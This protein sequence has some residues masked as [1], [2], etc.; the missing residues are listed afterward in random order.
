M[1]RIKIPFGGLSAEQ[2]D[3]L[4]ELRRGVLGRHPARHHAP[5][6]P[7]AL[8]PHRGHAR[9][10]APA[11]RGR[12]HDARGVRQLGPQRHRLPVSPASATT[13]AFDVTPY[14]HARRPTSC[15]A[16]PTRRTS[17][18][19]SR[20]RSPAARSNACG[21]TN[22]HDLGCIAVTRDGGRQAKRGFEFYVGGGLGAV[23]HAGQAASTSSCPRRSCCRS[24]RRSAACSRGSARRRTARA[25]ASSSWS[26]SSASRSS[27]AWCSRSAP[28]LRPD[29]RWTAFLADLARHRR[30]AAPRRPSRSATGR[31]PAGFDAWR[32]TNVQPQRQPGYAVATVTLPLGDLTADQA[33][34]L[35]DLSRTVHRRHDA[36]HRRAEPRRSA[37]CSEADLPALYAALARDRPRRR[38]APSTI[39]DITACPGTDTCKLGISSSRG[40]AGE[41]RKRLAARATSSD[42]GRRAARTSSAAAAST[43]AASTTSPTSASSASAATSTAAACRT[44][45]SW[46]AASG[47]NNAGA[48]GLAIGA[49]P[50]EARPRGGRPPDRRRTRRTHAEGETLPGASSS[51][52]ARRK[53]TRAARGPHAGAR[54]TS[55]TRRSTT[56]TGAT[57]ASTRSATWASASAPAR[58]SRSRSS[59]WPRPSASFEAQLLL[60]AGD[61]PPLASRTR[62]ARGR[63]GAREGEGDRH[64]GL[65]E[66]RR[67]FREHFY[68]T[69]LFFDPFAGG[70]FAQYFFQLDAGARGTAS[71]DDANRWVHD[72]GGTAAADRLDAGRGRSDADHRRHRLGRGDGRDGQCRHLHALRVRRAGRLHRERLVV[73]RRAR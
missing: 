60:D 15:S 49:V 43:P 17:G 41:L 31:F 63:E 20:S 27:S 52:S 48:Y 19:S 30:E 51:A 53:I 24:R 62:D 67:E 32:A 44:S 8:R 50:V 7:A 37:G 45:S 6:H 33:R 68:D 69:K 38:R 16:T 57:R 25:R 64:E 3:V 36:H 65:C 72:N 42:R 12:H 71:T 21:L 39:T 35:A 5:G 13:E 70:K 23:P 10:D 47:R 66:R 29:P 56:R 40:L 28:K 11:G 58:S 59:A 2:L 54:P 9:P 4:A 18:A 46:S 61:A 34:A 1:Q 55:R 14:A 26:R 73:H 22:I